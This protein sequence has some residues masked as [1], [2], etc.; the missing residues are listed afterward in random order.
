[1]DREH[2]KNHF[3]YLYVILTAFVTLQ[4]IYAINL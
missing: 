3:P 4:F 2:S 1:M